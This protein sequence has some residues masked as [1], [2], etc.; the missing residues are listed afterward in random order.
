MRQYTMYV[1][2]TCGYESKDAKK[3]K[4]HEMAHVNYPRLKQIS[5]GACKRNYPFSSPNG[6]VSFVNE[7]LVD[8]P[9][10]NGTG[11]TRHGEPLV[12]RYRSNQALCGCFSSPPP[13]GVLLN[14]SKGKDQCGIHLKRS[15]NIGVENDQLFLSVSS[16]VHR[17]EDRE[18]MRDTP[19]SGME[20]VSHPGSCRE[21]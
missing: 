21:H 10:C 17:R 16:G 14:R 7:S 12:L 6:S 4:E 8:Q 2:E 5:V 9:Q 19:V 18:P 20:D 13:C 1:C 15:D 11:Q 3:M